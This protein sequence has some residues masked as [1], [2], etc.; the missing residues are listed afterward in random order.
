[1]K[2]IEKFINLLKSGKA[3]KFLIALVGAGVT[4]L[5]SFYGH[6]QFVFFLF[7]AATAAG[8]FQTTNKG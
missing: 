2:E 1:M 8:V 7:T 3:N 6:N 4:T 5:Y